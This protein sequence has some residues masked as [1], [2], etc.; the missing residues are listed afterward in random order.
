MTP[1]V[2]D[3][4]AGGERV[5]EARRGAGLTVKQLADRLGTSPWAVQKLER[6]SAP[7]P[8][9]LESIATIT[10]RPQSFLAGDSPPEAPRPAPSPAP[11]LGTGWLVVGMLVVL[12]TIRFFTEVITLLPRAAQFVDIPIFILIV[13]VGALRPARVEPMPRGRR[14]AAWGFLAVATISCLANLTRVDVAPALTFLYG[15]LS[16][17]VIYWAVRRL[18]PVG[19]AGALTSLLIGLLL[20]QL[21]V[22]AVIDLPTFLSTSNPDVISGTF[23]ENAYQLVF[24]LLVMAALLAGAFTFQPRTAAARWAPVLI[25]L[26]LVIVVLAQYRALLV[27]T[28]LT[29]IVVGALVTAGNRRG[30]LVA[31]VVSGAFSMAVVLGAQYVPILKLDSTASGFREDPTS[32]F[33]QRLVALDGVARLFGD[34]PRMTL[35]GSGP[36]TFSSRAWKTFS[37]TG[38]LSTSES[39]VAG[40]IVTDLTEG[41]VYTTDVSER[42]VVPQVVNGEVVGGSRALTQPYSSYAGTLAET[43]IFGVVALLTLYLGAA[44][45]AARRTLRLIRGDAAGHVLLPLAIAAFASFF[46]LLQ[47]ALLENWFEV[48]RV[49][50]LAWTLLAVVA[51]EQDGRRPVAAARRHPPLLPSG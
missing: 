10:E 15:M 7:G 2:V 40:S 33:E 27:T 23:G 20:V 49:T 9:T 43:G 46:V 42:Y 28:A 24:F 14:V 32:F 41:R 38:A 4:R 8:G 21:I 6:G 3:H 22:V 29:I 51:R 26:T 1:T 11:A 48:T 44:A 31:V 37:A 13:L 17:V 12:V 47:M 34:R 30:A 45:E 16:P 5:R 39:N 36:G 35:T 18:W 50:F 25:T 19:A